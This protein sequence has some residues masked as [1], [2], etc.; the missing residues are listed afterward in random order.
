[1]A[2]QQNYDETFCLC[3]LPSLLSN[4]RQH[5]KPI[6]NTY[7]NKNHTTTKKPVITTQHAWKPNKATG[8]LS[9][10]TAL[11]VG[12]GFAGVDERIT[13]AWAN[14]V[15]PAHKCQRALQHAIEEIGNLEAWL[16]AAYAA[17]GAAAADAAAAKA[18]ELKAASVKADKQPAAEKKPSGEKKPVAEKKPVGEKKPIVEEAAPKAEKPAKDVHAAL[19]KSAEEKPLPKQLA[20]DHDLRGDSRGGF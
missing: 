8:G 19:P 12:I 6:P 2:S 5:P 10:T 4:K 3:R 14:G 13:K 11:K 7:T 16:P 17:S 9:V 18:E 15:E 20:V 1:L